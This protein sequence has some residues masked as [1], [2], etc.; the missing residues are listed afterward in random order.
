[1]KA[2]KIV[3]ILILIVILILA[4]I[5]IYSGILDLQDTDKD[6]D[7][8]TITLDDDD[9]YIEPVTNHAPKLDNIQDVTIT[10]GDKLIV[11]AYADDEDEDAITY[12][13]SNLD[14]SEVDK[15]KFEWQTLI[16]D[17]GE[18]KITVTASDGELSDT[19]SFIVYVEEDDDDN[20][21]DSNDDDS[22]NDDDSNTC[23]TISLSSIE[24]TEGDLITLNPTVNDADGDSLT[25]TYQEPFDSNGQWQT[26]DGDAG[27]YS[28]T[29]QVDDGECTAETTIQVDVNNYVEPQ[30]TIEYPDL[31]ID[32]LIFDDV[33]ASSGT[34]TFEA[35]IEND[36]TLDI[37]GEIEFDIY[38]TGTDESGNVYSGTS[39]V[40]FS[41]LNTN[42]QK[43]I[44]I[45]VQGLDL[46]Q[47]V[48][49]M[50]LTY[51][52]LIDPN[53]YIEESNEGNND[54]TMTKTIKKELFIFP[55]LRPEEFFWEDYGTNAEYM[56]F[57]ISLE[58]AGNIG[59]QESFSYTFEIKLIDENNVDYGST[60]TGII[61]GLGAGDS[62]TDFIDIETPGLINAYG[63]IEMELILT[64]DTTDEVYESNEYNNQESAIRTISEGFF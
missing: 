6:K 27:Q 50:A 23:P 34:M 4:G 56:T 15:N 20:D 40:T 47:I 30:T 57:G 52:G 55:D 1:M 39:R 63:E 36:G 18:Y 59:T 11:L 33:D 37:A 26:A 45:T 19:E 5:S 58:N 53:N 22:D 7:S 10:E 29:V 46:T 28:V 64:V 13:F 61:H 35:G 32:E 54:L 14:N 51:S 16:G 21:N 17:E 44:T 9:N 2:E 62:Y 60:Y 8:V 42:E 43:S 41:D 49:E 3:G 12:T 48:G 25:I 31:R 38:I 24:A